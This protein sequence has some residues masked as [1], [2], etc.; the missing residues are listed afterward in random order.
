MKLVQTVEV[1]FNDTSAKIPAIQ[2]DNRCTADTAFHVN[3]P[4]HGGQ[5]EEMKD[6]YDPE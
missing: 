1:A 6:M 5:T 2:V 4:R 3:L